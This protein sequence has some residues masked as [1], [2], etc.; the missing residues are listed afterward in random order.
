M[1]RG[2]RRGRWRGR[3]ERSPRGILPVEL[4]QLRVQRRML[5]LELDRLLEERLRR[6]REE[7]GLVGRPVVVERRAPIMSGVPTQPLVLL[8][9]HAAPGAQCA[10]RQ[11]RRAVAYAVLRIQLV[12]ELVQHDVVPVARIACPADRVV[13]RDHHHA[14][15][16]RLAHQ[17][18]RGRRDLAGMRRST[19]DTPTYP[20]TMR[21]KTTP[22]TA[23]PSI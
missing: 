10:R 21:T 14:V 16:P 20:T 1:S 5:A 18:R 23:S 17:A 12:R 22:M 11:D 7:L 19:A 8:R 3:E 13:P 9:K 6:D 4:L 15:A 2:D